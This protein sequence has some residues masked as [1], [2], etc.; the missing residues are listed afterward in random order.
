[1]TDSLFT[2]SVAVEGEAASGRVANALSG[3]VPARRT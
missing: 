2:A 1:M 3:W